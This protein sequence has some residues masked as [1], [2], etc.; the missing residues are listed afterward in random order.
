MDQ[1]KHFSAKRGIQGCSVTLACMVVFSLL[2][3]GVL[4]K[5]L[6][7]ISIETE[8]V[9]ILLIWLLAICLGGYVSARLGKTTGW[10]N[11]LVVGLL[12]EFFMIPSG[13]GEKDFFEPFL[14]MMNDP[15]THWRQ[16][17]IVVLTIPAAVLGGVI[18]QK[19]G[20]VQSDAKGQSEV[21]DKTEHAQ[22]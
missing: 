14:E 3:S 10:T 2:T 8:R 18:W 13:V 4:I 17:V 16:L 1:E 9:L 15:V 22:E 20:G 7:V 19:T 11:S 12:A 21:V 6:G 5:W